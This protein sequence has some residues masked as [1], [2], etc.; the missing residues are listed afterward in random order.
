MTAGEKCHVYFGDGKQNK[1]GPMTYRRDR[2]ESEGP[3]EEGD[4]KQAA[5]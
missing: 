3:A 2:A 1:K 4:E 5:L